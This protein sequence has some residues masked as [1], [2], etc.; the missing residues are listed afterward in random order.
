VAEDVVG[1]VKRRMEQQGLSQQ[2]IEPMTMTMAATGI[3]DGTGDEERREIEERKAG[4][5]L[6]LG[7]CYAEMLDRA[8]KYWQTENAVL[9]LLIE[10]RLLILPSQIICSGPAKE[11]S[12]DQIQLAMIK[13]LNAGELPAKQVARLEK[14]LWYLVSKWT[15]VTLPDESVNQ[16]WESL[17]E[18][19]ASGFPYYAFQSSLNTWWRKYVQCLIAQ[20]FPINKRHITIDDEAQPVVNQIA[21]VV[22]VAESL[23][24]ES[25]HWI[26]EGYQL[27]RTTFF[28]RTRCADG[29]EPRTRL[30]VDQLWESRLRAGIEDKD[31]C[32]TL[33]AIERNNPG[34]TAHQINN[35]YRRLR[36]RMWAY[37]LAR[38]ERL[39]N[40]QIQYAEVPVQYLR[41]E[42]DPHQLR[43]EPAVV[44]IASLARSVLMD[45]TLLWAFMAHIFLQRLT[46]PQHGDRWDT[47]RFLGELWRWVT[48]DAFAPSLPIGARR[49]WKTDVAAMNSVEFRE[50][51]E[52][53]CGFADITELGAHV[54]DKELHELVDGL[55]PVVQLLRDADTFAETFKGDLKRWRGDG[56][57]W[58][59]PM[60]YVAA[61][62]GGVDG[63]LHV[64]WLVVDKPE[65]PRL[66]A[67]ANR[68]LAAVARPEAPLSEVARKKKRNMR[69]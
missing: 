69:S 31:D 35:L 28:D 47:A 21:V 27:V 56:K 26:R 55:P 45:Q 8:V 9:K 64:D 49:G 42:E 1:V 52:R 22:N 19:L 30:I 6:Y 40:R 39:S 2:V 57:H 37:M 41:H 29:T 5:L 36:M 13:K 3:V 32:A 14:D 10:K 15:G 50:L 60:W 17:W 24:P 54:K 7:T 43:Q 58:I 67:M 11:A 16:F 53:L 62:L 51:C 63:Q 46:D 38:V 65:Q 44:T 20:R 61:A 66:V 12:S 33:E 48:D 68:M 25:L 23:S 18:K 59:A 34:V 4:A